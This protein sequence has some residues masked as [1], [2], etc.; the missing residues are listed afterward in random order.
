MVIGS[1]LSSPRGERNS[2]VLTG[3][4]SLRRACGWSAVLC[5]N[6]SHVIPLI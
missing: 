4:T 3:T 1:M 2:I 5:I 6:L